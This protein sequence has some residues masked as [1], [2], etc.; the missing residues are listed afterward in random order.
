MPIYF[1]L[2]LKIGSDQLRSF[3]DALFIGMA[4][5]LMNIEKPIFKFEFA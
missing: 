4:Q 3:V 1:W 2:V 5:G